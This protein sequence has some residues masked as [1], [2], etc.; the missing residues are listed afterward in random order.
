MVHRCSLRCD[1]I[2]HLP[3]I[4]PDA[5]WHVRLKRKQKKSKLVSENHPRTQSI[6]KSKSAIERESRRQVKHFPGFILHPLS[7]FRKFWDI[8]IFV[9]LLLHQIISSL[10]SS[11]IWKNQ[12]L[13]T[14]LLLTSLCVQ[15]SSLKWC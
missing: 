5:P 12:F 9:M 6:L 1:S 4:F 14:S 3:K 11:M 2:S 10:D 13:I 15:F 7:E 8:Y